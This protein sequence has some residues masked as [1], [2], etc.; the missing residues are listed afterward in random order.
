MNDTKRQNSGS[1]LLPPDPVVIL[2]DNKG[3][4]LEVA[5]LI[6]RH[7]RSFGIESHLEPLEAFRAAVAAHKP[8]MVLFNH[9]NASHLSAWSRRLA[10]IG[11]LTAVLPNEGFVYD[12]E[13]RP[14]MSGRF[15][16]PHVDHFFCWNAQHKEALMAEGAEAAGAVHIV[17]V[18]RF[19]FYFEPWSRLL[20][21]A[22]PRTSDKPRVLF[23]TNFV[24][25]RFINRMADMAA[26]F[27]GKQQK[28]ALVKDYKG[29]VESHFR[30]RNRVTEYLTSLLDDGRFEVVLRPHPIED[31]D[32]YEEWIAGLSEEQRKH[33]VYVPGGGIAPLILDCDL[34]I[35][36]EMCTTAVE[37]WI[38]KK[39]TIELIFDKHPML[40][41][42]APAAANVPFEGGD[43]LAEMVARELAAPDQRKK[44]ELRARHL[45]MWCASPD[46]TS[47]L[48]IARV[49]AEAVR[50]KRPADW[51]KLD[52]GDK[53][54]AVKLKAYRALG[55]AYHFDLLLPLKAKVWPKRYTARIGAYRKSIRPADVTEMH[56]RFERAA[57]AAK[58]SERQV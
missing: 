13:A 48:R 33:L 16:R 44:Q 3:R 8:S 2:V 50:A 55:Q 20:P 35:S 6:A 26:I 42:E 41:K 32:F 14:F 34:E 38:A 11:V 58:I 30:S 17:G 37:S 29:A 15:H 28:L 4:D 22:P 45:E 39:P 19:D 9:L 18:P 51:S 52:A 12:R 21:A 54:R 43:N 25:A 57:Q 31:K 40:Y 46:G 49:I 23:S 7:L 53:R 27:A 10:D 47:A 1:P 24:F 36:C 5:V 56:D